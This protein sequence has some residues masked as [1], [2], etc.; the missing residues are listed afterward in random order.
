MAGTWCFC[1]TRWS[2]GSKPGEKVMEYG[3]LLGLLLHLWVPSWQVA[4]GNDLVE[5]GHRPT[6]EPNK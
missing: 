3:Q 6:G 4:N 1:S 2:P 5:M